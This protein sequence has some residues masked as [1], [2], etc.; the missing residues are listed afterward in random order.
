[1]H[2]VG[3]DSG[4]WSEFAG[5]MRR[6]GVGNVLSLDILGHGTNKAITR[7]VA[8]ADFAADVRG[9]LPERCHVIGFSLGALVAQQLALETPDRL[10]SMVCVSSVYNRSPD[11]QQAVAGRLAAA[12]E[13]FEASADASIARWFPADTAVSA[14][15]IDDIRRMLK[16]NDVDSY[17][18]AYKVFA[19]ADSEL[20]AALDGLDI[21]VL[22]VTGEDDPG[23]TPAMTRELAAA[24]PRGRAVVVPGARH[25]L[26]CEK[27]DELAGIIAEF[28]HDLED[29]L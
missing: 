24:I 10:A 2:G 26:P 14:A 5:S 22:A 17:L 19:T 27:P 11:Q 15:R 29:E 12:R 6:R 16:A 4:M 28:I 1:M 13:N 20:S 18:Y 9:R 23:S 3:L 7:D 8:V 25:M 21:P